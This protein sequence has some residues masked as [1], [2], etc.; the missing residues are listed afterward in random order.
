M[1][2]VEFKK[3]LKEVFN[4]NMFMDQRDYHTVNELMHVLR[5]DEKLQVL[6]G[7][8]VS[9]AKLDGS[10]ECISC[11]EAFVDI[12]TLSVWFDDDSVEF[13][14]DDFEFEG[15]PMKFDNITVYEREV[16]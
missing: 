15:N 13:D 12:A 4:S 7:V 11:L 8:N 5:Y 10:W 14:A 2:T 9:V 1:T 6:K 16:K 3:L